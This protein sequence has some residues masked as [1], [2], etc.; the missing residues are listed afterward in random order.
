MLIKGRWAWAVLIVMFLSLGVNFFMLGFLVRGSPW[1]HFFRSGPPI[2]G[3]LEDF[4][5]DLRRTIGRQLRQ[6]RDAIRASVDA[7]RSKRQEIAAAFRSPVIDVNQVR[8][9]MRDVRELT[10]KLQEQAQETIL[11]SVS[12]LPA[13]ERARIGERHGEGSRWR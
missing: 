12:Q 13:A 6:D 10:V 2:A 5:P 4:P 3:M 7:I 1:P 9:L 8:G 11:T